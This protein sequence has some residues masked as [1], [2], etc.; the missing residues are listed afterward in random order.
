M[1]R[2]ACSECRGRGVFAWRQVHADDFPEPCLCR[3]CAGAGDLTVRHIA[4]RL[5]VSRE[6][7]YTVLR[8]SST[9]AV[10]PVILDAIARRFPGALA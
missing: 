4:S 1:I 3:A 5:G 10:G 9:R 7:V 8:G 6:N 2:F